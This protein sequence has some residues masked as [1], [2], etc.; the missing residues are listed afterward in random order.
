[1]TKSL[2]EVVKRTPK[3]KPESPK[4]KPTIPELTVYQK[5]VK[6]L[7]KPEADYDVLELGAY[8][9]ARSLLGPFGDTHDVHVENSQTKSPMRVVR[10]VDPVFNRKTPIAA[11]LERSLTVQ[12][13]PDASSTRYPSLAATYWEIRRFVAHV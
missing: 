8:A 10:P 4:K 13:P 2:T 5:P 3:P 6:V 11:L 7:A 12:R 1:V 9:S